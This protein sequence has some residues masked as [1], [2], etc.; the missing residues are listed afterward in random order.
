MKTHTHPPCFSATTPAAVADHLP[1]SF[2]IAEKL[3]RQAFRPKSK[4]ILITR[5]IRSPMPLATTRRHPPPTTTTTILYHYPT[6]DP[7]N[8][9]TPAATS[10]PIHHHRGLPTT[11]AQSPR[12]HHGY[13][14]TAVAIINTT[15]STPPPHHRHPRHYPLHSTN[16]THHHLYPATTNDKPHQVSTNGCVW[17][18]SFAIRVR[19]AQQRTVRVFGLTN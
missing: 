7:L 16:T 18:D 13:G 15:T 17:L 5:S 9:S 19:L 8:I 6:I 1:P 11:A 3:F 12:H 14:S 4:T 2:A 10:P